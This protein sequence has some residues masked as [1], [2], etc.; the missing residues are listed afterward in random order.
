MRGAASR[1]T[2]WTARTY[3]RARAGSPSRSASLFS[4]TRGAPSRTARA[5]SPHAPYSSAAI[6]IIPAAWPS[7]PERGRNRSLGSTYGA[8]AVEQAQGDQR[9]EQHLQSARSACRCRARSAA[10]C[11]RFW[12]SAKT[13]SPCAARSTADCW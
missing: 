7:G 13:P 12:I 6:S 9:L 8:V 5:R 11:G 2:A 3:R 4:R 1:L 10:T